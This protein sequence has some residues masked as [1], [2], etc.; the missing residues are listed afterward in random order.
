MAHDDKPK[1]FKIIVNM[2]EH[3]VSSEVMTYDQ[4]TQLA[5]PGHPTDGSVSFL[6]VYEHAESKPHA[7]TLAAGGKVTIKN[8]TSFDVTQ[9]NRS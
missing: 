7:G 1:H 9:T 2:T 5:F 4:V 6:V 3:T 8:H